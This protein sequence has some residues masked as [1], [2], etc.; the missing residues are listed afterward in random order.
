MSNSEIKYLCYTSKTEHLPSTFQ[1]QM[2]G[3]ED[4]YV[5]SANIEDMSDINMNCRVS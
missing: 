3:G 1:Y 4:D 2:L 5:L